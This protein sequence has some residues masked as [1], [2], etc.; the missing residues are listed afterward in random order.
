VTKAPRKEFEDAT[1]EAT[2]DARI[3]RSL[4]ELCPGASW[5]DVRRLIETG[6][7][8]VAGERVTDVARFARRGDEISIRM[9]ARRVAMDSA[10]SRDAIVHI[11]AQLVVVRKPPGVST[12]RFDETEEG[13]TLDELVRDAVKRRT[14]RNEPPLGVVHRL[15]KE[16]SGLLV[17][18]R[19]LTAKRTL[20]QAFRVHAVRRRYRAIAHG[21]VSARTITSRLVQDR[22]DGRRGS[23]DHPELGREAITHVRPIETFEGATLIEC[24]LETGRTHQIRI[25]LAEEGHSILGERVYAPRN[26]AGIPAPRLML[27]AMELGFEHPADGRPLDFSEPLPEDMLRVIEGLRR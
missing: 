11:D 17:F 23:T 14:G 21:R 22:G 15:D 13:V 5:G 20:K 8:Y 24:R 10:L 1:F 9:R 25:H 16:T 6:K 12:V 18:A 26:F 7:V 3:D 4:R 19:T 2:A 27:H